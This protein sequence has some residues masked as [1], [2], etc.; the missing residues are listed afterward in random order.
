GPAGTRSPATECRSLIL[1]EGFRGTAVDA[2]LGEDPGRD[3][4]LHPPS[5]RGDSGTKT[6]RQPSAV[7]AVSGPGGVEQCMS[8]WRRYICALLLPG[9]CCRTAC[10]SVRAAIASPMAKRVTPSRTRACK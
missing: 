4:K 5:H 2:A 1:N 8:R 6:K 9:S 3:A 10:H 7:S